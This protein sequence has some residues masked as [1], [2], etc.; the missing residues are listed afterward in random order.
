MSSVTDIIRAQHRDFAQ[1]L[2]AQVPG[3][4]VRDFDKTPVLRAHGLRAA[5][6]DDTVP[7]PFLFR[8]RHMPEAGLVTGN[9]EYRKAE[10]KLAG[11]ICRIQATSESHPELDGVWYRGFDFRRWE[12][13]AADADVG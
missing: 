8:V 6:G 5:V 2:K 7:F 11:Y 1:V 9:A 13:W 4:R 10:D 3:A 12:Y